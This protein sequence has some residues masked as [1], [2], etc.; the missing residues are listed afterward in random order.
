MQGQTVTSTCADGCCKS[1]KPA[2]GTGTGGGS[3]GGTPKSPSAHAAA[4]LGD[5]GLTTV[6]VAADDA[7]FSSAANAGTGGVG[8]NIFGQR[9]LLHGT[10]L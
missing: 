6:A 4:M 5:V 3:G 10:G 2:A 1:N 7:R 8:E 9:S